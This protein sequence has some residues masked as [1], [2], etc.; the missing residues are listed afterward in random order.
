MLASAIALLAAPVPAASAAKPPHDFTLTAVQTSSAPGPG[1][2]IVS[3]GN[4]LSGDAVV[5]HNSFS[6]SQGAGQSFTCS[7]AFNFS[8]GF[9]NGTIR[10]T[11]QVSAAATASFQVTGGSG[12]FKAAHG[13]VVSQDLT[14][15]GLAG[16]EA[17][18]TF[19]LKLPAKAHEHPHKGGRKQRAS[20]FDG[21]IRELSATFRPSIAFTLS[22]NR[23]A[24]TG[25]RTSVETPA[26][27]GA[28]G[29]SV[30]ANH[31]FPSP[32]DFPSPRIVVKPDGSFSGSKAQEGLKTTV[33]GKFNRRL[34][35][36]TG[37]IDLDSLSASGPGP[38][39][40]SKDSF[41]VL[42]PPSCPPRL[43]DGRVNQWRP[44]V[45]CAL[46]LLAQP[47]TNQ[48]TQ[49]GL[50]VIA[51]ESG[52]NAGAENNWD[53]NAK[54]GNPSCGLMQT[55]T[56]TFAAYRD[57]ALSDDIFDPLA[58]IYAGL[59]YGIA[60]YGTILNI[61]PNYRQARPTGLAE[62]H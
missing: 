61:P 27:C 53:S 43:G 57:P 6:C 22:A 3:K 56:T 24:L 35:R 33:K 42:K 39:C 41:Q 13:K 25:L 38:A 54:A 5:G 58:N 62:P 28:L 12:D 48:Y 21:T 16:S 9:A 47:Q 8:G 1:Q 34:T 11:G 40:N 44:V 45:A 19:K 29:L 51:A 59:N 2:S 17:T 60:H 46:R 37:T 23:T 10:A 50:N 7:G 36:A 18:L 30:G 52:G 31:T 49:V 4:L 32:Q 26:K 14:G 20:F 55:S 15:G